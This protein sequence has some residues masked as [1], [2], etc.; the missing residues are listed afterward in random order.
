MHSPNS[1]L[2]VILYEIGFIFSQQWIEKTHIA[3]PIVG[4]EVSLTRTCGDMFLPPK[5]GGTV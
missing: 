4:G 5:D 3:L 1:K 2:R